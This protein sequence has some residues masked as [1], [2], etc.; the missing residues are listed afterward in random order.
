[1]CDKMTTNYMIWMSIRVY[2]LAS[3][4]LI[5]IRMHIIHIRDRSNTIFD[6]KHIINAVR[7]ALETP[8]IYDQ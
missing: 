8:Y 7:A 3:T 4:I 5:S 1:M 2:A 6:G